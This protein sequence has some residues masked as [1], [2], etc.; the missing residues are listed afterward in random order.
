MSQKPDS[1]GCQEFREHLRSVDRRSFL[2]VGM[3]GSLGLSLS[4]LL[5]SD[6]SAAQEP[7]KSDQAKSVIILWMRGGPSHIDTWDLKPDAPVEFRGEFQPIRTKVP[8]IQICEHLPLSAKIMDKW[9]IVRSLYHSKLYGMADHSSGDQICFTGYGAGKDANVNEHPSCGSIVADQ[10]QAQ[11]SRMPSYVMI[12][13]MVPGTDSA[14]LGAAYRPFETLTDP[15]DAGTFSVPNLALP[16]GLDVGRLENRRALLSQLDQLQ[17]TIDQ[18]G[19]MDAMD[20]FTGRAMEIVTGPEAR[21]A[22]DL[23]REPVA[24]R[25]RYGFFEAYRPRMRAGGDRPQWSQRMLLARRLIEAGVR[26][27]TVD[28][29][30]WDTH[31]DNFYALKTAFLPMWDRAY[32]ALIEDLDQ[33]GL[34]ETTLVVAWGEMGRS[35][36]ISENAGRDHWPN[37]MSAALA[38]GG[39]RGGRV[40]GA[41]D[42]KGTEPTE[43]GKIPQDVLATI[44]RHLG[45]DTQR[46]Y[47]DHAGRPHPVLPEGRAIDELF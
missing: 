41:T 3:L 27:V 39:V 14:Y 22:F 5:R 24:V 13:R 25:D 36:R 35:P 44:Y 18:S 21:N 31:E 16:Q 8:G 7:R 34:L 28:C 6:A 10:F 23:E 20:R 32:S 19:T 38:G 17:R 29:R 30:W 40:V 12:P 43:N 45:V 26:L 46:Q 2:K 1:I 11:N 15:A 47:N 9:S 33:R 37:A 4:D 42:R